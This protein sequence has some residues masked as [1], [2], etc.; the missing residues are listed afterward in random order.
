[1][2]G[3]P[4]CGSDHRMHGVIDDSRINQLLLECWD[5]FDRLTDQGFVVRPAIPILYFGDRIKYLSS[6]LK[7]ITV[8]LNPSKREFP[9]DRCSRFPAASP[10][11]TDPKQ[12]AKS[13][14]LEALDEYFRTDPY[15][16]WFASFEP[17][18][19]GLG[20][21]YYDGQ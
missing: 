17:I 7:V 1:M 4:R 6:S 10:M 16:S 20:A 3:S 9:D 19:N 12:R 15:G 13:L 11:A 18:L 5:A 21:S 8:G 14:H 2:A